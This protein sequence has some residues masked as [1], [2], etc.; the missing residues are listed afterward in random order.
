MAEV[1]DGYRDPDAVNRARGE[2]AAK[3]G[4]AP[5]SIPAGKRI[6]VSDTLKY[7]RLFTAPRRK[8]LPDGTWSDPERPLVAKFNEGM[9]M[10]DEKR[11]AK[12]IERM[13]A[14]EPFYGRDYFDLAEKMKQVE[15]RK[16][17]EAQ[18]SLGAIAATAEGR[19]RLREALAAAEGDDFEVPRSPGGKQEKVAGKA[20]S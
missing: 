2:S 18:K 8:E 11:D 5:S 15:A 20:A 14:D 3:R 13:L 12:L 6:F 16:V 7:Q 9:L 4:S 1:L 10:L 17:E 19:Q